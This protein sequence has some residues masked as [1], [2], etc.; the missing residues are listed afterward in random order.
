MSRVHVGKLA[1]PPKE[2]PYGVEALLEDLYGN[3]FS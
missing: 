1:G 2:R 3:L